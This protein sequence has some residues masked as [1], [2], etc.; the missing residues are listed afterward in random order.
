MK[1][2]TLSLYNQL[3]MCII[4]INF[5]HPNVLQRVEFVDRNVAE[6]YS[7]QTALV[8]FPFE[9]DLRAEHTHS[10]LRIESI[11]EGLFNLSQGSVKKKYV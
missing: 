7:Q 10:G 11:S 9:I 8:L 4:I 1:K 6:V 2:N 3:K 5:K